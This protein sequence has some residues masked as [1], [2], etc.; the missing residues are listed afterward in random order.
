VTD[1]R[2]FGKQLVRD[3]V[4]PHILRRRDTPGIQ[5]PVRTKMDCYLGT[6]DHQDE[7][8]HRVA[9]EA[10]DGELTANQE[11]EPEVPQPAKRTRRCFVCIAATPNSR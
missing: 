9:A 10:P 4:T 6:M 7:A 2:R 1:S 8:V 3:L 5:N 11:V